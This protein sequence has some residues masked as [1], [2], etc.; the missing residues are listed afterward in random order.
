MALL[1]LPTILCDATSDYLTV[2]MIA[3]LRGLQK[4]AAA[5][6]ARTFTPKFHINLTKPMR[7]GGR[8]ICGPHAFSDV[9]MTSPSLTLRCDL[10]IDWAGGPRPTLERLV[11]HLPGPRK[12]W[13]IEDA[14]IHGFG[15]MK[16]RGTEHEFTTSLRECTSENLQYYSIADIRSLTYIPQAIVEESRLDVL[17]LFGFPS[18]EFLEKLALFKT[19][20]KALC[21]H[22]ACTRYLVWSSKIANSSAVTCVGDISLTPDGIQEW[23]CQSTLVLP[24]IVELGVGITTGRHCRNTSWSAVGTFNEIKR[25]FPNLKTIAINLEIAYPSAAVLRHA[26]YDLLALCL[27]AQIRVVAFDVILIQLPS[28]PRRTD[29]LLRP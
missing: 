1:L 20:P 22:R 27:K 24:R 5:T 3:P 4:A 28:S 6:F 10:P 26:I 19:F 14:A 25:V 12:I 11:S 2:S 17:H 13:R 15:T 23:G 29:A 8:L 21:F 16:P 7:L 9:P 18:I